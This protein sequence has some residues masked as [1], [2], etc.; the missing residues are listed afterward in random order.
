MLQNLLQSLLPV[1]QNAAAAI[2]PLAMLLAFAAKRPGILAK[3][4]WRGMGLGIAGSLIAAILRFNAVFKTREFFEGWV[5]TLALVAEVLLLF[6]LWQAYR[7]GSPDEAGNIPAWAVFF[8]PVTLGLYRG[9]D[10]F[11]FSAIIAFPQAE[12]AWAD[13]M[14]RI[15]GLS[16][17]LILAALTGFAIFRVALAL[18]VRELFITAVISFGV[19]MAQQT[20]GVIQILLVRGVLPMKKWLLAVMIPLINHDNWFFFAL[21]AATLL[22]PIFLFRRRRPAQAAGLNPA[23]YRK[24]V[25]DARKKL[26]WGAAA[27]AS[28]L[29]VFCLAT[30]GRAYA[31]QKAELSPAV[32]VAARQ[33]EVVVSLETVMDGRLHRFAYTGSSGTTVRFIIVKKGGSSYGVGLDACDI[34]GPTGYYERDDQ[35]ICKLCDVVMNKATI[36]FKGGCNPVPL[37]YKV[38]SGNIVI[39]AQALDKEQKRFG[40]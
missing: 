13:L 17:G 5:L 26:R 37:E 14:L 10:F 33:G 16:L 25:A 8:V 19:I 38:S 2:I 9:L 1:L 27:M 28:V 21:L 3:W 6:F 36:G 20:V 24:I 34:C 30:A 12:L 18:P 4:I 35:I 39:P 29:L 40:K 23:Q 15:G 32:P 22:L 31:D 7:R 11:L